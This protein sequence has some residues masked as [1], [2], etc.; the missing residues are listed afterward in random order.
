MEIRV[1][2]E[3][4]IRNYLYAIEG[5][6]NNISNL[7]NILDLHLSFN[8]EKIL[9]NMALEAINEAQNNPMEFERI[10]NNFA[11]NIYNIV[12]QEI[13]AQAHRNPIED[14]VISYTDTI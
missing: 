10:V 14:K 8:T 3:K 12:L 11:E 13:K 1:N 6:R 7:W 9:D 4:A 5:E 2:V